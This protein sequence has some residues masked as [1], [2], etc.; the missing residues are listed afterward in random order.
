[1]NARDAIEFMI[2]GASSVAVGTANFVSPSASQDIIEGIHAY[3]LKHG[4][5]DV[6]D[7]IGSLNEA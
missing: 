7:L 2:A 1:M 5:E 6:K 4:I 3:L